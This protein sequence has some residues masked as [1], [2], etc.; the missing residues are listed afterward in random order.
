MDNNNELSTDL[1]LK[2]TKLSINQ[3]K[4]ASRRTFLSYVST[5]CV[6]LSLALAYLKIIDSKLDVASIIMFS[7]AVLFLVF[8]VI[9]FVLVQR[10]IKYV[11]KDLIL[12]EKEHNKNK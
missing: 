5:A 7:V 6:F 8:G 3:T 12:E 11:I 1:S 4:M 10:S 9:D 2:R